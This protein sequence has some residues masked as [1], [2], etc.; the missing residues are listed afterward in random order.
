MVP[1]SQV[2]AYYCCAALQQHCILESLCTIFTMHVLLCIVH[3][4]MSRI[5]WSDF[6][7]DYVLLREQIFNLVRLKCTSQKV[8]CSIY[9]EKLNFEIFSFFLKHFT[10]PF[11]NYFSLSII[12]RGTVGTGLV[13]HESVFY[14]KSI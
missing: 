12:Y 4:H 14:Q 3:R 8:A 11:S 1:A 9:K 7:K 13:K 2:I 10:Q 5:S 6:V